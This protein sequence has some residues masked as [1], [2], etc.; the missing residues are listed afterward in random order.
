MKTDSSGRIKLD[1]SVSITKAQQ[2]EKDYLSLLEQSFRA[3]QKFYERIIQL[4]V[5]FFY[6]LACIAIIMKGGFQTPVEKVCVVIYI[7]LLI[8][9]WIDYRKIKK[10]ISIIEYLKPVVL[11]THKEGKLAFS[12][13]S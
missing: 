9:Y 13:H 7:Y 3:D 8:R 4:Y 2:L 12:G 11:K 5:F 1:T 6:L 10:Q